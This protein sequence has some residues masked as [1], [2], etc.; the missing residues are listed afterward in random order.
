VESTHVPCL[1]LLLLL[2]LVSYL[3]FAFDLHHHCTSLFTSSSL[4]DLVSSSNVELWCSTYR[5]DLVS[6]TCSLDCDRLLDLEPSYRWVDFFFLASFPHHLHYSLT[7]C[8]RWTLVFNV[9]STTLNF[10]VQRIVHWLWRQWHLPLTLDCD[11]LCSTC[12]PW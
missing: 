8:Q 3:Y 11:R 9:S 5:S 12:N 7:W 4:V 6:I 1:L 10:G 2:P